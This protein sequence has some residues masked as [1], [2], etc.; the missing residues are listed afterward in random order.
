MLAEDK[1]SHCF[2][3]QH[4]MLSVNKIMW[5]KQ[6]KK[7]LLYVHTVKPKIAIPFLYFFCRIKL[8]FWCVKLENISLAYDM[9]QHKYTFK[10]YPNV[11]NY[12]SF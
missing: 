2:F 6:L 10:V 1:N 12:T 4:F 3:P 5:L 11:T 7:Q 8:H 9:V